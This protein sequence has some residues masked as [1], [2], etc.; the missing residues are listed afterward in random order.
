[1][2]TDALRSQ[3]AAKWQDAFNRLNKGSP[4]IS[5][6]MTFSQVF[7]VPFHCFRTAPHHLNARRGVS[8]WISY[9]QRTWHSLCH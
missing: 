7:R 9:N 4:G 1:M 2:A 3:V 6:L 5:G 8:W